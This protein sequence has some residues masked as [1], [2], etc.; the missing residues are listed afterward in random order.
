MHNLLVFF[1]DTSNTEL[2]EKIDRI[3]EEVT[4]LSESIFK[5]E[6]VLQRSTNLLC[7]IFTNKLLANV[8]CNFKQV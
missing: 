8:T 1:P 6:D 2:L 3:A 7:K 4:A 5:M